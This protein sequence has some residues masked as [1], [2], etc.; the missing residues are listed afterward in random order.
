[1]TEIRISVRTAAEKPNYRR[2]AAVLLERCREFYQNPDN[3]K[4]FQEWKAQKD[5]KTVKAVSA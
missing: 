3:E 5:A 4:A 1:M 2:T